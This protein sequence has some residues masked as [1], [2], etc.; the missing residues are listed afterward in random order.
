MGFTVAVYACI[1][2]ALIISTCQLLL[3]FLPSLLLAILKGGNLKQ[4]IKTNK[5]TK[6]KELKI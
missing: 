4:N 1:Y 5:Q 6:P 2:P 3:S